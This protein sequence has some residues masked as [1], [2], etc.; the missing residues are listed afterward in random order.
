MK[1]FL[2]GAL[3]EL[4]PEPIFIKSNKWDIIYRGLESQIP[5]FRAKFKEADQYIVAI[6]TDEGIKLL[7]NDDLQFSIQSDELHLIPSI[8]GSGVELLV[9]A[10]YAGT[11]Y[12]VSTGLILATTALMINLA[13]GVAVM[14]LAPKPKLDTG[15][16]SV[17]KNDSFYF[18]GQTNVTD[19]GS[20]MPIVYGEFL[21]GSVVVS[22][23][24]ETKDLYVPVETPNDPFFP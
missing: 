3:K 24:L 18:N 9:L 6:K 4:S 7:S 16:N 21:V 11:T 2:H 1:I 12:A 19:A 14:L 17:D 8:E 22:V 20:A 5:E 23:G 13:V 10:A 15:S